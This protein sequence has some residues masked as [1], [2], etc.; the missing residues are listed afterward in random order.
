MIVHSTSV[1]KRRNQT[2]RLMTLS[3]TLKAKAE[4][5]S[6]PGVLGHIQKFANLGPKPKT[7]RFPLWD[8]TEKPTQEF[9]SKPVRDGNTS[10]CAAHH[11]RCYS[12]LGF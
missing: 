12:P 5:K 1:T 10:Y 11:A 3:D 7:C 4:G 9:C 6:L 8:H 2:K